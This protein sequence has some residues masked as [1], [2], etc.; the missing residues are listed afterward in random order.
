MLEINTKD[1]RENGRIRIFLFG[2]LSLRLVIA[3]NTSEQQHCHKWQRIEV[4]HNRSTRTNNTSV[5]FRE[6]LRRKNRRRKE[7]K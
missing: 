2:K 3:I 1:L 5:T 7:E 4:D 6:R